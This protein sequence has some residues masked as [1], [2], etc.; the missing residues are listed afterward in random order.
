[1][2]VPPEG[3][4][5]WKALTVGDDIAW[6]KPGPDGT[7]R[8]INPEAGFFGVAPGTSYSSNPMAMDS[9]KANCIF[10]NVALT[11]DG[12]IW[13][14]GMG[15][16]P[17]HAIDWQGKDWTPDAGRPAAHP[18]ARFTA[19]ASQCPTI[20]PAWEDPAGVPISAF[21]FGGRL[22][23]T[24]PLVFQSFDW[25]HGVFMAATMGSEATAAAIGQAAIRRDPFAM[26]P[27]AGYNM[28]EYWNHWLGMGEKPGLKLPKIFR[29]NWFR[30]DEKGSFIWPGYGQNMRV[31]KWIV[32]RV[33][34]RVDAVRSPFGQMPRYEDITWTGL[35]FTK[36][37]YQEIMNVSRA[38]AVSEA[39]EVK[40]YFAK[41][42]HHLPQDLENQ[43][44]ALAQRAEKAPEV[45]NIAAA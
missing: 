39:N 34:N 12:D 8:A 28:A 36:D 6:I 44:Q 16:A 30:K 11:D 15:P 10:T 3:F 38:G 22:S 42:G 41:F 24:F 40:D 1:M 14:E 35:H 45:W 32:D 29:V 21:I 9:V 31:V 43:R 26:L 19:P 27:F 18:N 2:I 4:N 20:D 37:M 13:W 25:N 23:K 5:G 17:K 33:N 7:L